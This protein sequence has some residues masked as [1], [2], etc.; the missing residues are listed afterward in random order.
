MRRPHSQPAM[1]SAFAAAI[2]DAEPMRVAPAKLAWLLEHHYSPAEL[3]FATLKNA[4]LA[5]ARVLREA[6]TAA[7]CA[8]HL[9]IV[10]IAEYGLAQPSYDYWSGS[11][12]RG[13]YD[14]EDVMEDADSED[15]EAIEVSDARRYV[16]Q[17]RD[18]SDRAMDFGELPL[19]DGEVLPAG[20]LDGETP[21]EQRLTEATGNEGASFERAYH[22][23][24]PHLAAGAFCRRAAPG[25]RRCGASLPQGPD[26]GLH[27]GVRRGGRTAGG[28]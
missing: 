27:G 21:D 13:R 4:D 6:A 14:D 9:G 1:R 26:R 25:G 22:R 7:D 18:S 16:D 2:D 10:H 19:Q 24:A 11:R 17:W 8:A 15:F 5:L 23:A 12:G 20:A 28:D 3:S